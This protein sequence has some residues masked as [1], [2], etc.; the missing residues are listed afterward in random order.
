MWVL[1]KHFFQLKE[2]NKKILEKAI[3]TCPINFGRIFKISIGKI[4]E[5]LGKIY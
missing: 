1:K 4:N 3:T 2:N 5:P